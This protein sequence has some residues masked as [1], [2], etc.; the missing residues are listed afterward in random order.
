MVF[1]TLVD[2][3]RSTVERR[4]DLSGRL[5]VKWDRLIVHLTGR[6][7][8]GFEENRDCKALDKGWDEFLEILEHEENHRRCA[9]GRSL[10]DIMKMSRNKN[11]HW[12]WACLM[13]PRAT[14][15]LFIDHVQPAFAPE[16]WINDEL[17]I[18]FL[19][20]ENLRL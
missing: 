11:M 1:P 13:T 12:Y 14:Y 17:S 20:G 6:R 2:L 4:E 7:V 9:K 10:S 5:A 19:G 18:M 15:N 16:H 3:P 8:D